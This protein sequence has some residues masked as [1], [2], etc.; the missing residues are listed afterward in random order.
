MV[1]NKGVNYKVFLERPVTADEIS[2]LVDGI[3]K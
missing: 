1:M 2:A 3:K